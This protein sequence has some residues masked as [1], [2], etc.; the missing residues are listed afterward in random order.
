M[1]SMACFT[2]CSRWWHCTRE[3]IPFQLQRRKYYQS[4]GFARTVVM[5][6]DQVRW[7]KILRV[8]DWLRKSPTHVR[9]TDLPHLTAAPR[10]LSHLNTSALGPR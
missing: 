9:R 7:D 6:L 8:P 4:V 5:T 2:S 1:V 3:D 10:N